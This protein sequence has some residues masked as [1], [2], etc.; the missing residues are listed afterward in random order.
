MKHISILFVFWDFLPYKNVKHLN[1]T[2]ATLSN[3][4]FHIFLFLNKETITIFVKKYLSVAVC[5][6]SV[7]FNN[8]YNKLIPILFGVFCIPILFGGGR[9]NFAEMHPLSPPNSYQGTSHIMKFCKNIKRNKYFAK[10]LGLVCW[11]Q[12]LFYKCGKKWNKHLEKW[13]QR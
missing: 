10:T 9:W 5:K 11:R 12:H 7:K 1:I 2:N 3:V 4:R 8:R 6:N 13:R